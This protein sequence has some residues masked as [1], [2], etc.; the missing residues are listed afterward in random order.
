[1]TKILSGT[2]QTLFTAIEEQAEN[3]QFEIVNYSEKALAVFGETR[4][5]K[6][7][8]KAMGGKFNPRLTHNEEKKAGWIFSKSKQ[9]ELQEV[10]K[11]K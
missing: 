5:I 1:M 3:L 11:I 9:P 8:L 10:L 7:Q 4:A 2:Q 6:D